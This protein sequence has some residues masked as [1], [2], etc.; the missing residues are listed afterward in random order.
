[1]KTETPTKTPAA[2]RAMGPWDAA[3]NTLRE[4]DPAWALGC[5]KMS[6]NP[7]ATGILPRKLVE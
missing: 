7:W 5:V 2:P 3:L 6:T 1:M 4:W